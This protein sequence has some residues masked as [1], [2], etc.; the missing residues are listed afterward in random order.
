MTQGSCLCGAVRFRVA[1]FSS[2]IYKCHCS[3][4]RKAFGGAASAAAFAGEGNFAWLAGS[5]AVREYRTDS[6][7]QRCFC[8]QCG[9]ILPQFLGEHRMYWVPV[10]LLDSEPGIPLK[11][12]I[13]VSSKAQWDILD[14][15][16]RH[17]PEGFGS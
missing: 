4:C 8:P 7:F 16:T 17:H 1:A 12:H 3:K 14:T 5:D 11:Q 6:G 9:C 15:E 2:A 13:H 10:G